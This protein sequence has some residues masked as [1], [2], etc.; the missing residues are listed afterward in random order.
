MQSAVTV[1]DQLIAFID[2][3]QQYF[4]SL[5][6]SLLGELTVIYSGM[7]GTQL[8]TISRIRQRVKQ[9]LSGLKRV[10]GLEMEHAAYAELTFIDYQLV[11]DLISMERKF[12]I[13]DQDL[14]RETM[15]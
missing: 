3:I 12:F 13:V 1:K 14:L 8:E 2:Q 4:R 10:N 7:L 9:I 11:F 5:T 15:K 6:G